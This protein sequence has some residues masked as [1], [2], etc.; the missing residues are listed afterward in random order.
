MTQSMINFGQTIGQMVDQLSPITIEN[1]PIQ[2]YEASYFE[3][4]TQVRNFF[5][6]EVQQTF[7]SFFTPYLALQEGSSCGFVKSS[8]DGIVNIGCNQLFPYINIFSSL[9]I[10]ASVFVF[11]LFVISYFLTTRLNFYEFLEGNYENFG[12]ETH[13]T[14]ELQQAYD[15]DTG[16]Q[17][18]LL[19]NGDRIY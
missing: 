14:K 7:E 4:Y 8:M 15:F 12:V 3:Y 10:A 18:E 17:I 5:N 9:N 16:R 6:N 11:F 1:V 2:Q 19:P 13:T